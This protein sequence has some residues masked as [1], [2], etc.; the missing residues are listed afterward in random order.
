MLDKPLATLYYGG[1]KIR[2]QTV[3]EPK[4]RL[5]RM[6]KIDAATGCWNWT[7]ALRNGYG[8][9]VIGSRADK[10]RRSVSAHRF[11]YTTYRGEIGELHVCHTC[12]NR[13]CV[14]PDHLFLGTPKDNAA[15]R[16]NKGRNKLPPVY[17]GEA[18]PW[19]KLSNAQV[20]QI[21][22]TTEPSARTAARYGVSEGH[23]RSIRRAAI[24]LPPPPQASE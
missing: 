2:G 12:D 23:I 18:A 7:G 1:M 15:D 13:R 16:D 22:A 17:R 14:N 3:I 10:S 6:S 11:S 8:R 24:S 20:E 5:R 19:A 21:R 9:M 4:E